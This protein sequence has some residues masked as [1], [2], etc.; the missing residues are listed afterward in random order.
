[1]NENS[2]PMEEIEKEIEETKRKASDENF[3]IEIA[4]EPKQEAPQ[5]TEQQ[6]DDKP[7]KLSDE[8]HSRAVQTRINKITE[9]RRQAELESKKYQEETAQLK[10]RLERLER[11]NVQQQTTQAQNQFQ[12]QYDLTRQALTKAVEEGDT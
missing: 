12:Q 8:E 7:K 10:A 4:E 9:Q 11:N 5:Q 6:I 3:E 1:M 2:N